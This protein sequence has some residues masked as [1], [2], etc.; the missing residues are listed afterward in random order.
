VARTRSR[1]LPQHRSQATIRFL[2]ESLLAYATNRLTAEG[3]KRYKEASGH[4]PLRFQDVVSGCA[5]A[6][7]CERSPINTSGRGRKSRRRQ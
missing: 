7:M 3:F 2:R 4:A 1:M 6:L 5:S